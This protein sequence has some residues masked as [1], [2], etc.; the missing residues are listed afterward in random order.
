MQ[1]IDFRIGNII[2]DDSCN[3]L[4]G[5]GIVKIK[6]LSENIA[7]YTS[8]TKS[9]F[10]KFN[11]GVSYVNIK[12][13]KLTEEWILKLG[14]GHKRQTNVDN[15]IEYS[16]L[17]SYRGDKN[18]DIK[19]CTINCEYILYEKMNIVARKRMTYIHELQNFVYTM[20]KKELTINE[21]I[22][23]EHKTR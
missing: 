20:T 9:D 8:F 5:N 1:S 4:H 18:Y 7:H 3:E 13:V 23:Y 17:S 22:P 21:N 12:G 19:M 15:L 10:G 11:S 6:S 14:F 2:W 16:L